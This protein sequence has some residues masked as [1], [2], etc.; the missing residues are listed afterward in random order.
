MR[1]GTHG[2]SHKSTR[3]TPQ[4]ALK[5]SSGVITNDTYR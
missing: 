2:L 3:S 4:G 5:R 1:K